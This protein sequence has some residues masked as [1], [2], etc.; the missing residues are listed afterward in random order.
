MDIL[1]VE[2]NP[3]DMRLVSEALA[4]GGVPARL[5]WA[6]SGEEALDFLR[7]QGAHGGQATPDLV[8]L[9]LNLPGLDGHEVLAAMKCDA[10]LKR[11]PVVVLTSSSARQDVLAAY[12]AH[13]N[14]YLVKPDDYEQFLAMVREMGAYWLR[15][16]LL[17]SQAA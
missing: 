17:P 4:E 6:A 2:D 12:G 15:S 1:L 13:A 5:H 10:A 3:A 7:R 8:L 16:V 11:I 14:A 9:D